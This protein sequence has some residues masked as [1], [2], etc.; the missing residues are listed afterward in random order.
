MSPMLTFASLAITSALVLYTIGVFRDRADGSLRGSHGGWFWT[1]I[2][3]K[4]VVKHTAR[5]TGYEKERHFFLKFFDVPAIVIM[6]VMMTGGISIRAFG[7]APEGFNAVFYTGLGSALALAGLLFACMWQR[8]AR[9][10]R[11]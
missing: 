9:V 11:A 1:V 8:E 7:L 5:I 3:G 10:T 2:F 4:L 6:A